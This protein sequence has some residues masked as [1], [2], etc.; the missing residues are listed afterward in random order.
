MGEQ[1]ILSEIDDLFRSFFQNN[2]RAYKLH[3]F[4]YD[5]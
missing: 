3:L 1:K 2:P 4:P 5:L